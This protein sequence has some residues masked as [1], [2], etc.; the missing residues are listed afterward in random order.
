MPRD[1]NE[2]LSEVSKHLKQL[3]EK[4]DFPKR[5]DAWDKL[6]VIST[7]A[8]SVIIA[9]MGGVFTHIYNQRQI[10]RQAAL[11]DNSIVSKN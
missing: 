2:E 7:F 1:I 9:S 10:E 5:K 4:I 6:S 8:A 3:I 11:E